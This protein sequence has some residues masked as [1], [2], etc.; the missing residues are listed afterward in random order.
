M[1]KLSEIQKD[2][3]RHKKLLEFW[4]RPARYLHPLWWEELPYSQAL[5]VLKTCSQSDY[6]LSKTLIELKG[7]EKNLDESFGEDQLDI[8]QSSLESLSYLARMAAIVA[9][10]D[11]LRGLVTRESRAVLKA[12]LPPDQRDFLYQRAPFMAAHI[13]E[14]FTKLDSH[15]A[16]SL[17][18]SLEW[19]ALKILAASLHGYSAKGARGRWV[20]KFPPSQARTLEDFW[21]H[22]LGDEESQ[23]ARIL[24]RKMR[25]ES[26]RWQRSIA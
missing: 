20:L 15:D 11:K 2:V 12:V 10:G 3:I 4:S 13:P 7:L 8:L 19:C 23:W 26:Q 25:K 9:L 5:E 16:A 22:E 6:H 18:A 1:K 17:E 24:L 21:S 14:E